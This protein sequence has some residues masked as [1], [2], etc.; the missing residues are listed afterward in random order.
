MLVSVVMILQERLQLAEVLL[1]VLV[2]AAVLIV[3]SLLATMPCEV[4]GRR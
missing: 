3:E 4:E 2:P 1:L